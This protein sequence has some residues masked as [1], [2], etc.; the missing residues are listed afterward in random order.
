MKKT[1]SRKRRGLIGLRLGLAIFVLLTVF[2]LFEL[3][4]LA[5]PTADKF[6]VDDANG[7]IGTYVTVPV[8]ITNTSNS[9]ILGIVFNIAYDKTVINVTGVS[10]GTLTSNWGNLGFNNDFVWGTRVSLT[11]PAAYAIQNGSSGSV[12]LLNFRV[13]DS[14]PYKTDMNLSDIQ[15]SDPSGN[16][17]P[18][19]VKNGTFYA[20]GTLFDTGPGT[21]PSISGTHI[22]TITPNCDITVH[23]LYTYSCEGTGGHTEYVWI[24]GPNVNESASWDGYNDEYQNIE[25]EN[26]FKLIEGKKYNYTIKTGSYPQIVHEHS[27]N[28]TGGE[29][30]CTQFTDANGA[31]YDDCIP[32]IMFV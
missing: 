26:P 27:K 12:V 13:I 17:G 30:T 3:T 6:G 29:I 1:E 15:L 14:A 24:Q 4:A 18:A 21:Y 20:T 32:A 7:L 11:G 8:N 22:G 28:V 31:I 16:E 2:A 10:R 25:F 23:T 9:P 5:A 19:P